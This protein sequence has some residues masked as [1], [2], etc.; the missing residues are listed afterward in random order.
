M[1]S[2]DVFVYRVYKDD[3]VDVMSEYLRKKDVV[4]NEIIRKSNESSKFNS[5]KVAV[6]LSDAD[7]VADAQ[8]WPHGIYIRRCSEDRQRHYNH[9]RFNREQE[10][11]DAG[12]VK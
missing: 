6:V 7:K 1:P 12:P 3:G 8:F 9:G 4:V 11:V 2:R 5:F 10:D